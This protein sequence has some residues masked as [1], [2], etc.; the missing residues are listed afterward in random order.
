MIFGEL[1][2]AASIAAC[3]STGH[4]RP[5]PH[6]TGVVKG[7]EGLKLSGE[8]RDL[9]CKECGALMR[10]KWSQRNNNWFYGCTK[11]P[12]CRNT[13]DAV[14]ETGA[15]IPDQDS[16]PGSKHPEDATRRISE[17]RVNHPVRALWRHLLADSDLSEPL[18]VLPEAFPD[19]LPIPYPRWKSGRR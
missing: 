6:L 16:R 10:C 7:M 11:F 3:M 14:Q 17:A 9:P 1:G 15:P 2:R 5:I 8:V 4:A 12:S 19:N 18:E 13:F